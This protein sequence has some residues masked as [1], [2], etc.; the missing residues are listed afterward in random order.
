MSIKIKIED[1]KSKEGD[2]LFNYSLAIRKTIDGNIIITDHPDIDII[3]LPS[4]S[5]V[6]TLPKQEMDDIV[7]DVQ[8]NLFR[9]L[10]KKGIIKNDTIRSGNIYGSLE[11]QI[12]K[13][14]T[15]IDSLKVCLMVIAD[16]VEK[17]RENFEY[18]K[19]Y[20]K[21]A[22]ARLADPEEEESTELGEVPHARRKGVI[23]PGSFPLAFGS[24][25]GQGGGS[26]YI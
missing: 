4:K 19:Q 14:N 6:L 2:S 10:S 21:K 20:E 12:P 23:T 18:Y 7:Y 22:M 3:V 9:F 8:D 24:I 5:K 11:G 15:E 16:F 25:G 13:S 1:P 17:E 26:G